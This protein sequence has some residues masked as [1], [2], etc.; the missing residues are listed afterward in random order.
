MNEPGGISQ[1]EALSCGCLVIARATGGLR[2]TVFPI[3][4]NGKKV[5]GNGFLF[6]D[7]SAWAFYDAIERASSF[8]TNNDDLIYKA[9]LIAENSVS[10]WDRSATQYI[11]E[12]YRFRE[13]IR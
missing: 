5:K 11:K 10:F 13:V 2:D 7:F 3:R 9:R 8:L 1:L 6:T 12:I 4:I